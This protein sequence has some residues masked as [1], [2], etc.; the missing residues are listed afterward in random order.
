MRRLVL[1][2]IFVW[3]GLL[4]L[5]AAL[6]AQGTSSGSIAGVAKDSSGAVLP[7]VTVEASSPP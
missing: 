6:R 1:G 4:L 5:P 7:G 3:A 2:S